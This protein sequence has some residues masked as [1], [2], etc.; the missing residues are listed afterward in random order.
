MDSDRRKGPIC[1]VENCRSRIYD[2]G[3]D[4]YRY[5]ENGHRKGNLVVGLDED[6]FTTEARVRTRKKKDRSEHEKEFKYFKGQQATDLYLKSLQLIL[7]HQIW[8]LVHDKGLPAELETVVFDLWTL[9]ILQLESKI[10]NERHD[11][12]SQSQAF[13]TSESDSDFERHVLKSVRGKKLDSTPTLMDCLGLCYLGIV[14]LRL[15]ITHGD[16]HRWAMQE[17]MAYKRAIKYIPPTMKDRLPAH[18][19]ASL[20]PNG[21]LKLERFHSVVVALQVSFQKEHGIIW[22]RLNHPLLLFRYMKELA[23]PLEVYDATTQLASI[24]EYDFALHTT[25]KTM[26]GLRNLPEAQLLA[27]LVISVKIL[28]P[29]D[30]EE[31]FAKSSA[32]PAATLMDWE[33][34]YKEISSK[35]PNKSDELPKLSIEQLTNTKERDVFSMTGGDMDRYMDWYQES[36]I[37]ESRSGQSENAEFRNALYAM[38]P[39]DPLPP[40]NVP[41]ETV[42]GAEMDVIK[43]VQGTLKAGRVAVEDD[44]RTVRPGQGYQL[45]KREKDLDL[46]A[47]RFYEEAARIAG[48]SMGML[49]ASVFFAEKRVEKWRKKQ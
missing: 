16:I 13:S 34:W 6:N 32:E 35:R 30:G 44:Q 7:R 20:D 27:C 43:A 4:G 29:F 49:V 22:P 39:V 24:L 45:Y 23:L 36:F 2:E 37:D 33:T 1:G 46:P 21:V 5:C 10:S 18:Y 9:R 47:K 14:T 31:R 19:H 25:S 11:Y 41:T 8:F 40:S 48:L 28:Y 26:L 12:D 3:E 38:F 17:E 42:K 15:P